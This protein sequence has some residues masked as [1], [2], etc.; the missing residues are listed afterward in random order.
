MFYFLCMSVWSSDLHSI[1]NIM[2]ILYAWYFI[3]DKNQ[4]ITSNSKWIRKR[5]KLIITG[6]NDPLYILYTHTHVC[7]RTHTHTH[8][9]THLYPYSNNFVILTSLCRKG[10]AVTW[11]G[12]CNASCFLKAYRNLGLV[13]SRKRNKLGINIALHK[14]VANN[15]YLG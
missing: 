10:V 13:R 15:L 14:N 5:T 6:K 2:C 9:H 8:T 12:Y 4:N 3:V 1:Q 7:V 11:K